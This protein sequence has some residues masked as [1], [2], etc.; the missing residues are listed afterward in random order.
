MIRRLYP[1]VGTICFALFEA[2][3]APPTELAQ[4]IA[5]VDPHQDTGWES[6]VLHEKTNAQWQQLANLLT[7]PDPVTAESVRTLISP[8]IRFGKLR[9]ADLNTV[10]LGPAQFARRADR[11]PSQIAG[12]GIESFVAALNA[13][14]IPKARHEERRAVFKEIKIAKKPDGSISS[15]ALLQSSGHG[16]ALAL[17]QN[18][19]WVATWTIDTMTGLPVISAVRV[20][21]FEEVE[22]LQPEGKWLQD[23]TQ[24]VLK[25]NPCYREQ[26]LP[27]VE[28][29]AG[30]LQATLD[31]DLVAYD[32]I[33][34]GDADGDGVDD[35]Y[36]SQPGGLPNRLFRHLPDGTAAD[37]S[38]AAGVDFLD[39][40]QMSLFVDLDNDGD[41]DLVIAFESTVVFMEN[42]GA[43]HFEIRDRWNPSGTV[44]GMSAADYDGDGALD[45]YLC[46][47]GNL[48]SGGLGVFDQRYPVP[49]HDAENGAPNTLLRNL[50]KF[51]FEDVT[52][53]TGLHS[54]NN[55]WSL[56]CTWEDFDND[57]DLDLYI[58]NDFGRNNLYRNDGGKFTDV[59]RTA[60]AEDPG[61][62]MSATWGDLDNDGR[63]D[64][65]VSNMFSGAGHR[66]TMQDHFLPNVAKDVRNRYQQLAEGNTLLMNSGEGI[67]APASAAANVR[68]GR[69]AWGS[70]TLD[71]NNDGL[72]DLVVANGFLTQEDSRD[73]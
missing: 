10:N 61:Q 66:I 41:Q 16:N 14:R 25:S 30:S 57:G 11:I 49:Y 23:I 56:A 70:A 21:R 71:L 55:R 59:A 54:N 64:L 53:Q 38:A 44:F 39:N 65:Y 48:W 9:P 33:S 58:A 50:G 15:T 12:Q 27:G 73:L 34:V 29:W 40:G 19:T 8:E 62:G 2:I 1:L 28:K 51:Q 26:F 32:G 72:Q 60:Q 67:F 52:A 24:P 43:A 20:T 68:V 5:R 35:L 69:W 47:Y 46:A 36:V 45:L 13:A 18:S 17:Q 6:E 4:E 7:S 22:L 63:M 3:A 42:D 37:I 31:T